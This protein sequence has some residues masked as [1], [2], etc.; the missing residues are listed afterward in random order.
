MSD[1]PVYRFVFLRH[2]ESVGNVESRW[3]GQSDYPLTEKGR[4]QAR[5]LSERWKTEDVKFD[6]VIT[7]TLERAQETARIATSYLEGVR[8]EFN[9][10]LMERHIGQMEGM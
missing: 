9:P 2:A 3:Q 4:A 1:K 5:A 8:I 10:I 6:L 7:S